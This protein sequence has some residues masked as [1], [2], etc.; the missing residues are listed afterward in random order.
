VPVCLA[1]FAPAKYASRRD[2]RMERLERLTGAR[3]SAA[4]RQQAWKSPLRLK[5]PQ[6]AR[7]QARGL[8]RSAEISTARSGMRFALYQPGDDM[9]TTH[10]EAGQRLDEPL[11]AL[12]RALIAEFL[13]ERN[14]T[15]HSIVTLAADQQKA[16]LRAASS[17][18]TLRLSEIEARAR[19]VD[20]LSEH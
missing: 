1:T 8:L 15:L 13:A 18:A 17:Y 4:A 20:E 9:A 10:S 3:Q 11:A 16:L 19:F 14:H 2:A 7:C 5:N 12:E 6:S